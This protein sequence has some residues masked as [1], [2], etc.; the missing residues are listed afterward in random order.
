MSALAASYEKDLDRA[1]ELRQ[2]IPDERLR[3]QITLERG[4]SIGTHA[5]SFRTLRG[6]T[7]LACVF[8]EAAFWRDES[9]ANPDQA[10]YTAVLPMLLR[11]GGMLIGDRCIGELLVNMGFHPPWKFR[12]VHELAF[13]CG[14]FVETSDR[15]A[16][17]A[18]V[19]DGHMKQPL[20][21]VF[22]PL[23]ASATHCRHRSRCGA[24]LRSVQS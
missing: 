22:H 20:K 12:E 15:S 23:P 14:N 3:A 4:I 1:E 21:P 24:T 2:Q 13:E 10:V 16:E 18:K 11:T 5:N 9:S 7:L 17:M 6:R 8:D 19:R